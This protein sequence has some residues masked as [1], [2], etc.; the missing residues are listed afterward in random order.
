MV[1]DSDFRLLLPGLVA[2]LK[3]SLCLHA[4]PQARHDGCVEVLD[5]LVRRTVEPEE[6]RVPSVDLAKALT[7]NLNTT[8]GLFRVVR[9]AINV[10]NSAEGKDE[11]VKFVAIEREYV[12]RQARGMAL[13]EYLEPEAVGRMMRA[14]CNSLGVDAKKRNAKFQD[15]RNVPK[16]KSILL[17]VAN[18]HPLVTDFDDFL[19]LLP[20]HKTRISVDDLVSVAVH[21][22][23]HPLLLDPL[24]SNSVE[25]DHVMLDLDE[26]VEIPPSRDLGDRFR[27]TGTHYSIP[28]QKLG[29]TDA[30]FVTVRLDQYG[31]SDSHEHPGDEFMMCISGQVEFRFDL[32]GITTELNTGDFIHFYA[33]QKH[34]A[35][36]L[37]KQGDCELFVVRFYHAEGRQTRQTLWADVERSLSSPP[38]IHAQLPRHGALWIRQMLPRPWLD[39]AAPDVLGL[40][41]FLQRWRRAQA[42]LSP[43]DE[44]RAENQE[45]EL[46]MSWP[47]DAPL[48]QLQ[49]FYGIDHF[50][51]RHFSYPAFPG[52]VVVRGKDKDY[53]A[54]ADFVPVGVQY[55]LPNRNLA[56]SDISIA[57]VKMIARDIDDGPGKDMKR[58]TTWN[59]HPGFE[60][61]YV[62][63]GEVWV[64]FEGRDQPICCASERQVCHFKSSTRHRVVNPS[65]DDGCEYF[66]I[67]FYRDGV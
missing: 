65:S 27:G 24:R 14:I 39:A 13:R 2:N 44:T 55:L 41:R 19:N 17:T 9:Q 60:A 29:V 20:D 28:L 30:A 25:G 67:R 12:L 57:K 7:K 36:R 45:L 62:Q 23:V 22:G 5:W 53:E 33:E 54:L 31:F 42:R 58:G 48:A 18:H 59:E 4:L 6:K 10:Y 3:R 38:E 11:P 1:S 51:L 49:Q 35:R 50:L 8:R 46:E 37:N 32:T 66:V 26:F 40:T 56:C 21:F 47:A 64:Y 43:T 61:I 16:D 15:W 52:S 34:S 63:S